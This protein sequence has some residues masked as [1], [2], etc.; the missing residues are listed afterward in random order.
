MKRTLLVDSDIL[1]YQVASA[2]ETVAEFDETLHHIWYDPREVAHTFD[3]KVD[4]W[5]QDLNATDVV[6]CLT[7]KTNFRHQILPTYKSN[8]KGVRKPLPMGFLRKH[9]HESYT[10]YERDGLE[11][12]DCLGILATKAGD[13]GETVIVSLDKDLQQIPGLVFRPGKDDQPRLIS[14]NEANYFHMLQTLT[15]D[16]VD[17]YSGCPGIGPKRAEKILEGS[18]TRWWP[19]VVAAYEKAGLGAEEAL[20][21]ARVARILRACDYSFVDKKPILWAPAEVAHGG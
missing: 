9:I 2:C 3:E 12:D 15:G 4:Q 19:A 14:E 17:G 5:V 21:Q 13:L 18:D 20:R 16:A 11:A 6:M 10:T 7:S 1:A 8:R